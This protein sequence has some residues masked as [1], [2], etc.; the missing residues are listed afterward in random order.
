MRAGT[1]LR[2]AAG[3]CLAAV[4]ACKQDSPRVGPPAGT[5]PPEG[6]HVHITGAVLGGATAGPRQVYVNFTLTKDG[7]P[8][9]GDAIA[10]LQPSFTLAA[11]GV[12]PVTKVPAWTSLLLVGAQTI[13]TL[14]VA[15]P[16]SDATCSA[17]VPCAGILSVVQQP[18]ADTGGQL[19]DHG[20]GRFTY[21][22][23]NT[24]AA[25][26]ASTTLRVG[27]FLA[28]VAGT[29]R[30]SATFDFLPGGALVDPA[31]SR[32][33]VLESDCDAC[34]GAVKAHE[35]HRVGVRLCVTC[36]TFQNADPDTMDPAAMA[37]SG[38]TAATNPN[39][40]ELGRL[41]HRIHRGRNLP[42]LYQSSTSSLAA[43]LAG[44]TAVAAPFLASRSAPILGAKFSVVGALGGER[45]FGR[46]SIRDDNGQ[47]GKTLAQGIAF[48]RDY[49]DCDACHAGARAAAAVMTE[50]SRRS[51]QGCHPDVWFGDGTTDS[52]HLAHPGGPQP[53]DSKCAD[54]HGRPGN[55]TA[56]ANAYAPIDEIHV[57][58]P[59]SGH[60]DRPVAEIVSVQDLAP[61]KQPVV[62]F[63]VKDRLGLVSPLN[64]TAVA[65]DA[66]QYPIPRG[67]NFLG[68]T[69]SGPA[70][71]YVYGATPGLAP[72]N[73]LPPLTLADDPTMR[74]VC[75]AGTLEYRFTAKIPDGASGT[76][77]VGMEARR[78]GYPL[79]PIAATGTTPLMLPLPL[80][81]PYTGESV[82]EPADNPLYY[83]DLTGGTAVPPRD[84]V[85]MQA[86]NRCHDYVQFH[87]STRHQIQY[88]AMCHTADR[89]DW[90]K[91][92]KHPDTSPY[93][94]DVNLSTV[95][96]WTPPFTATSY[97]TYDDIEER[98]IQL[99]VMIH[100]IHTGGRTGPAQLET[101]RPL[102]GYVGG[103][104]S[105][106]VRFWDAVLFPGDLADCTN[107]HLLG[108]YRTESVPAG[109]LPTIAN[110]TATIQHA[111][112]AAHG[113]NEPRVP[114][115]QSACLGCHATAFVSYHAALYTASGVE[116]CGSCHGASGQFGV[117][118]VHG[119]YTM[120]WIESVLV[121]VPSP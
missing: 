112:T 71:G 74:T 41:V 59:R 28:A 7:N 24:V 67:L 115:I 90:G 42:T 102:A 30:T 6:Y 61:G 72:A 48:P 50:L 13:A 99:K 85:D 47:P 106:G 111:K 68:I 64:T 62:C 26:D 39:P 37:G 77:A 69:V 49:R 40:L 101:V 116:Q 31:A 23:R 96:V 63:R 19:V 82:Y 92:P 78:G 103:G 43:P 21:M 73:E 114:P 16:G 113:P 86:C 52:S 1:T 36:H 4:L 95:Y 119:V 88:C 120:K 54:C 25:V 2:L 9:G 58:P 32:E 15:G 29:A 118:K 53:D 75:P 51:C 10:A 87:G 93:A 8:V 91:R 27:A 17:G 56:Y 79:H 65:A 60:F 22:F 76:W 107:C 97:G 109:A 33:L 105:T 94:G 66:A 44:A 89:T 81:W 11:L 100:R 108:T 57:P 110:E 12:E 55:P 46:V 117:A 35:G 45:V 14:P 38:A 83:Q 121:P 70:A 98:S 84:V 104:G 3:L 5:T 80:V 34:H 20:D 18:G